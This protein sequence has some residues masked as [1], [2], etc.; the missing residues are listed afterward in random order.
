MESQECRWVLIIDIRRGWNKRIEI[1]REGKKERQ[2][3]EG[4]EKE[5]IGKAG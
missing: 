4:G 5:E 1:E 2:E 3:R